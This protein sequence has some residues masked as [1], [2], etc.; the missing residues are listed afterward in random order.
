[1]AVDW[2]NMRA[3]LHETIQVGRIA[4][5]L[6]IQ[7]EQVIVKL[8]LLAGWF[9]QHGKYGKMKYPLDVVDGYLETPGF[10]DALISVDWLRN[11][12]GILTLHGFCD[13]STARKSLGRGVR[14]RILDGA[15]CAACG[16]KDD[17]EIDHST[18]IVRGGSCDESNLQALCTSCNRAKGR[19]TMH[20]FMEKRGN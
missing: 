7:K 15:C 1:M 11:Q 19:L 14:R 16:A 13:V 12:N 20:E 4:R 8:Y 18:P 2:I 17:L 6:G 10:A 9:Q 3:R 5:R